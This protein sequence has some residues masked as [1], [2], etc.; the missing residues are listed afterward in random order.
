[1]YRYFTFNAAVSLINSLR[2]KIT[3]VIS[4]FCF[5][6]LYRHK[7]LIYK[8][9]III[10][11]FLFFDIYIQFLVILFFFHPSLRYTI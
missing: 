7:K 9:K 5:I 4:V 8:I 11:F 1:M 3:N 10:Y 2:T 6:L